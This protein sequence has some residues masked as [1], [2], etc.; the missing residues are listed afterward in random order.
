MTIRL[1]FYGAAQNVTGSCYLLQAN[2][3]NILID[4]GI[5]QEHDLKDRNWAEFPIPPEAVDAVVLTHAH[6]DHCGRVPRLVAQGYNGPVYCS[7]ATADIAQIVMLDCAKINEEDAEFKRKRHEKE[8][9]KGPFPEQP[10]YTQ[11]DAEAVKPFITP[12]PFDKPLR[13]ATGI[14]LEFIYVAH[15]LGAAFVRFTIEENGETRKIVFSGDVGRCDMPILKDPSPLGAADYIV[16]ESTY[17]D[18]FHGKQAEIPDDLAEIVNDT[19][20]RG[21]NIIIPSFAIERT[22]ELI[23]YLAKLL[24]ED[25]IPHLRTFVD[26]PMAVK[27]SEV[28]KRHADLFDEDTTTL[29]RKVRLPG[30]TMVRSIADSKSI[31]HIK[32]TAIIIAG[33]GMCTGGRIKHHLAHNIENPHNTVLFVGYQAEGTLGREILDGEKNVRILG[34]QF[35]VRARIAKLEGFSAHADQGELLHWLKTVDGTPK[36]LFVTHGEKNA[37]ATFSSVVSEKL[38]WHTEVPV[39]QQSFEL[40]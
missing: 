2:G 17:G 40:N 38:G 15:I 10:L 7:S 24:H 37:A 20:R 19:V 3:K 29:V 26:S 8:G 14:T 33:S 28:F 1:G 9:R 16:C 11:T 39:Y 34:E 35:T 18:R 13:I 6:L 25:K 36:T 22:Q 32:G 23:Y 12:W 31:N 4:C 27:V 21:G 30:L 5:Y